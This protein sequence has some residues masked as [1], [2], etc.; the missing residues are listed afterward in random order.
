LE[1]QDEKIKRLEEQLKKASASK[2]P[3]EKQVNESQEKDQLI[4]K[5]TKEIQELK[6]QLESKGKGSNISNEEQTQEI[7]AEF[8]EQ[9]QIVE[10]QKVVIMRQKGE[11]EDLQLV[12]DETKKIIQDLEKENEKNK[13]KAQEHEETLAVYGTQMETLLEKI[14]D[15]SIK[16]QEYLQQIRALKKK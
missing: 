1:E 13:S 10:K 7:L 16:E 14:S 8:E 11:L 15:L 12:L 5:L 3:T 9:R 4:E 2:S 6:S